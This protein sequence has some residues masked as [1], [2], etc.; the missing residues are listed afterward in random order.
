MFLFS[1]ADFFF[2]DEDFYRYRKWTSNHDWVATTT[3]RRV[4]ER[5]MVGQGGLQ[6]GRFKIRLGLGEMET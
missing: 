3:T 5:E 4:G 2:L 6:A 1:V